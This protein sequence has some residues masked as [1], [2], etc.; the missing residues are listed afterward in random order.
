MINYIKS[1]FPALLIILFLSSAV[2][3]APTV[4]VRELYANSKTLDGQE[5]VFE[6]E[7]IG[8]V[9]QRSE[10]CWIN[11]HDGTEAIGVLI[12]PQDAGLIEFTGSYT[13]RG[14][15]VRVNAVF[16]RACDT[17]TGSMDLHAKDLERIKAGRKIEHFV[18]PKKKN[19][20]V[21]VLLAA[22]ITGFLALYR[23]NE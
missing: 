6:G 13:C 9:I 5:V 1:F 20:A 10:G 4:S 22:L 17:H 19:A 8:E 11:V 21:V 16:N 15:I 12:R 3:A 23:K 14:D 18:S 7:V 2:K